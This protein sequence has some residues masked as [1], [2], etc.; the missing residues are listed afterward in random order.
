M[1]TISSWFVIAPA[2]RRMCSSWL[3][4][5]AVQ[6]GLAVA[7]CEHTGKRTGLTQPPGAFVR[8]TEEFQQ[9]VE[10]K[11]IEQSLPIQQGRPRIPR[12]PLSEVLTGNFQQL[13]MF[14]KLVG[15]GFVH[16]Q[17]PLINPF[18]RTHAR[19]LFPK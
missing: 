1:T 19:T 11:R 17:A 2:A 6:D 18:V 10:R 8:T 3:R 5:I 9:L 13:G 7:V 12:K 14:G 16:S 4:F 15:N